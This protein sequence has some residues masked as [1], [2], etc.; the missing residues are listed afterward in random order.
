MKIRRLILAALIIG[1]G[2]F[3]T[4]YGGA[5]RLLFYV[6][7]MIPVALLAYSFYVRERF[8]IYQTVGS[9]TVVKGETTSYCFILRNEDIL[10]YSDIKVSF[11]EG[12]SSIKGVDFSK[13]YLL[14]PGERFERHT[15]LVCRYR[16]E[17]KIG[18]D[19]ISITDFFG[20]FTLR[21][22]SP[23]TI[24][25]RVYPR[26][27]ELEKLSICPPDI[28]AKNILFLR[29]ATESEPDPET[30][31]YIN[32]DS[33]RMINWKASAKKQELLTRRRI[34]MTEPEVVFV[35]DMRRCDTDELSR[36][37]IE[38]K[39]I[40]AALAVAKYFLRKSK[41]VTIVYELSTKV[42]IHRILTHA[43]FNDFYSC[44][45]DIT[46]NGRFSPDEIIMSYRLAETHG[47]FLIV[48]SHTVTSEM[49]TAMLNVAVSGNISAILCI[50]DDCD[51][52]ESMIDGRVNFKKIA[53]D[54]EI[55][56]ALGGAM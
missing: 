31:N 35:M 2:V 46:F 27:A 39:I 54:D 22:T 47:N 11:L 41:P 15:E 12:R 40:E 51:E 5:A 53:L 48:A 49:S 55:E 13:S 6:A 20:I 17:Y 3:A 37:I 30:R 18:I 25:M 44:C 56:N 23:S 36:I 14:A 8:K 28:D 4:N 26:V 21:S 45:A 16:G 38:D 9:K 29:N 34:A 1:S 43:D 42:V 24:I 10:T 33:I 50:N 7:L 52:Y 32:G 19:E